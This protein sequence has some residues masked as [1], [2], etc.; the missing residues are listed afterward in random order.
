MAGKDGVLR[1]VLLWRWVVVVS[2]W[3]WIATLLVVVTLAWVI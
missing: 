1:R 3:R 2:V